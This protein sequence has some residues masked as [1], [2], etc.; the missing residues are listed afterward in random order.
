VVLH[1]IISAAGLGTAG[2]FLSGLLGGSEPISQAAEH[3]AIHARATDRIAAAH[4]AKSENDGK[5]GK[6]HRNYVGRSSHP[7]VI[8]VRRVA[9]GDE[10]QVRVS[11]RGR[12]PPEAT[13][14]MA[15]L[16]APP[17]GQSHKI[18]ARLVS[19]LGIVS[20]H[21][22]GRKIEII[23]GYRPFTP[24]QWTPH[25]NHNHGRAVDFRVVGVPNEVL[26]DFCKTLRNVGCG[27]YPNSVFIHM[28]V[29]STSAFW[30]DYSRPGERPRYHKANVAADEGTSDVQGESDGKAG[31]KA[32][33]TAD[34]KPAD[35]KGHID[36]PKPAAGDGPK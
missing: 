11:S 13:K 14:K 20:D 32:P 9:T 4:G 7:G 29:R 30:I 21:F 2:L 6:R 18:D 3:R 12:V 8:E 10:A 28:D 19:L 33:E 36:I 5:K 23:S 26:R 34:D 15:E 17:G 31:E 27:Y 24:K 16:M 1:R 22:A 35:T 25:S